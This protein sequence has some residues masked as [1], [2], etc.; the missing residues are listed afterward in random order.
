MQSS[1]SVHP[2]DLPA[3]VLVLRVVEDIA[4]KIAHLPDRLDLY[5]S[6]A[7]LVTTFGCNHHRH[8]VPVVVAAVHRD[9]IVDH[10]DNTAVPADISYPR[11]SHNHV[12]ALAYIASDQ[13]YD[14]KTR[15]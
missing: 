8:T 6:F 13:P 2:V 7:F 3:V 4:G 12:A 11:G 10:R 1:C 5:P 14:P 15:T 9:S